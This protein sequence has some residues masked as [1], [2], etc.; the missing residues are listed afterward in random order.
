M[1]EMLRNLA[2]RRS[3]FQLGAMTTLCTD[4]VSRGLGL[5][6]T[7]FLIRGLRVDNYAFVVL[8]LAVGQFVGTS[9]TGGI[10]M[11]Y[12]RTEAERVSRGD[13]NVKFP[14]AVALVGGGLLLFTLVIIS[15]AFASILGIRYKGETP[16]VFVMLC[17]LFAFSQGALQ[18]AIYH[19]QAHLAF[20]K[21]GA[22]NIMRGVVLVVAAVAAI[23]GLTQSGIEMTVTFT[24]GSV[25][26]A[27][28][29]CV[30]LVALKDVRALRWG[31]M[32]FGP[33]TNWLTMY[34]LASAGFATLD[35][36]IVAAL[37]HQ[38]DV[39]T[40]GASQRYY[41]FALGA[42]PALLAVVRVRTS[43]RDV[44]DSPT[45]QLAMLRAWVKR[46]GIPALIATGSLAIISPVLIPVIDGGRY[47]ESVPVFQLLLIGVCAYY[48]MMPASSL[49]M[50]QRR[51]QALALSV[52]GAFIVNAIGD[53]AAVNV[54]GF[55]TVGIAGVASISY[56]GY[57]VSTVLLTR[58]SATGRAVGDSRALTALENGAIAHP[59][60]ASTSS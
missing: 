46:A 13:G 44:I 48:V 57:F 37:L 52:L 22:V 19:Y 35:V 51:Y 59:Q 17:G 12:L 15:L 40:F 4:T 50:A 11:R 5:A 34:Y 45:L 14:F 56:V 33:E 27:A 29:V 3:R 20:V 58:R 2:S 9:I 32:G 54:F 30:P 8:F 55:R 31:S 60:S 39:A 53:I 10:Q 6:T 1:L 18:L 49:L 42:G 38:R 41:A 43:Q 16:A 28:I 47:P 7:V 21:A 25:M 24:A 23:G 26:A 36:F